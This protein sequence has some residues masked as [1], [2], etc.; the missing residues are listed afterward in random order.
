MK[1]VDFWGI[2]L[3]WSMPEKP[4]ELE[5]MWKS[6]TDV[7]G[8][9][10]LYVAEFKKN[11]LVEDYYGFEGGG[12]ICT[13][14]RIFHFKRTWDLKYNN[15]N[16]KTQYK[17]SGYIYQPKE[18]APNWYGGCHLRADDEE[19]AKICKMLAMPEDHDLKLDNK[20]SY[21][22][23]GETL[24]TNH[25]GNNSY[26]TRIKYPIWFKSKESIWKFFNYQAQEKHSK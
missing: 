18:G 5:G 10:L 6:C 3:F 24:E 7:R 1:S 22:I 11:E 21:R 12:E 25:R 23:R 16:F 13:G 14:K 26:L 8:D 15:F 4:L 9:S 20:F 2:L 19:R 17:E